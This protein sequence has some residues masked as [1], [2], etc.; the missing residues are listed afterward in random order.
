MTA[1]MVAEVTVNGS[2]HGLTGHVVLYLRAFGHRVEVGGRWLEA[3]KRWALDVV[4]EPPGLRWR[5]G[6]R[7]EVLD[8]AERAL[9]GAL[10][11]G[12]EER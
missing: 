2:A 1:P 6:E 10:W 4:E 7:S 12:Q 11:P 3:E 9:S 5:D 8:A